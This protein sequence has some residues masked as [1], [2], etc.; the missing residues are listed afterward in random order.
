[1][2]LYRAWVPVID[3]GWTRW[4]LENYD[5]A[6]QT[7][8]NGDI[9]AGRLRE[10]FD[11]IILPDS[12]NEEIMN[13]FAPGTISGEY[14]GGLGGSGA[15]A[16][17]EFVQAG[18]TLVAFNDASLFA[19]AQF[20]LPVTNVLAGLK[21]DQ[22]YCSGSLIQVE[23]NDMTH[24]AV[25]GLPR[26]PIVMFE[27]GPSLRNERGLSRQRSGQLIRK[28]ETRLRAVTSCIP[29]A[30]RERPRPWKFNTATAGSICSASARSGAANL[31]APTNLSST[32]ST[33]QFFQRPAPTAKPGSLF[34]FFIVFFF[35]MVRSLCRVL[36]RAPA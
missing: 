12:G 10:R 31:T 29:S 19:I 27:L 36:S 30:S 25:W 21:E 8:R 22:F 18:G 28:N 32:R 1:M 23:L 6:P 7:L 9:Q 4:V 20:G 13:G 2:G 11:V 14:V 26:D 16:L 34:F 3:E 15:A 24:P 33:T 5:F 17:R 35:V